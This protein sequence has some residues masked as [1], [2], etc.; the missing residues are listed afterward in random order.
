VTPEVHIETVTISP[1]FALQAVKL[2]LEG[3]FVGILLH[4]LYT[5]FNEIRGRRIQKKALLIWAGAG[6]NMTPTWAQAI[7][8]HYYSGDEPLS[9]IV[10]AVTVGLG[11]WI[12]CTWI[13]VTIAMSA[14]EYSLKHLH[15]PEGDVAYDDTDHDIW[16]V[17]HHEV[18]HAEHNVEAV[19]YGMVRLFSEFFFS[20]LELL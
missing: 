2:F 3:L 7:I 12:T 1:Y 13:Q 8:E 4:L 9:N 19:I 10:D 18:I 11:I 20:L 14:A 6:K 16:S 5:E 17:Y 15:R